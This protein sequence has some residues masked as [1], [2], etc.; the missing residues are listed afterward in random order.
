MDLLLA[1]GY[2][3]AHDRKERKIMRPYPPLGLLCLTSY[4]KSKGFN[5]GIFDSTF[6]R[7][8]DFVQLL[9]TGGC[10]TL[11]LYCNLMTRQNVLQMIGLA[12]E[13]GYRVIL[14]G[15]EPAPYAEEFIRHGADVV[16]DGEGEGALEDLLREYQQDRPQ[17]ERIP[18]IVFC[19]TDGHIRRTPARARIAD[20][21]RLPLPDRQAI[22]L[23]PYMETWK[24]RH[25][26]SS[27]SLATMRGCPF[28]C[29]WC[30]RS[31]FGETYRRRSPARV[32]DEIGQLLETYRPD[33]LWFADDVFTIQPSWI[34][35]LADL[36]D[37]GRLRIRFECITRADRLT[38][39]VTRTLAQM[40][41]AR[42]W[43]GSES[44]SQRV[45]DAMERGV[46]VEQIRQ[47]AEWAR[48]YGIQIGLFIMFGYPG[49]T[50]QDI[51]ATVAHVRRTLPDYYMSTV[52]YPIK[53]TAFY[54]LV[55]DNILNLNHTPWEK[56]SDRELKLSGRPP[57]I[58]YRAAALHLLGEYRLAKEGAARF[59]KA[60][61]W[62]Y[63]TASAA[64]K[65]GMRLTQRFRQGA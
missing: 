33:Q 5:V 50:P 17:L 63:R 26:V 28:H 55:R 25:G 20:L 40:G 53:G 51:E 24:K 54:D 23:R 62:K 16:V 6:A 65:L 10:R 12:R 41:C 36:L 39:E 13:R 34:L 49:E 64:G 29:A 8:R 22:D 30:S 3:L 59:S 57:D 58:Y 11:G 32:V 35:R 1:H 47:A 61:R 43:I 4:L 37:S 56:S 2:F 60:R 44:G 19:D 14:G 21:D 46:R 7:M 48:K 52:A 31:V 9:E 38:D 27:L 15:P 45:L 18:G 42:M